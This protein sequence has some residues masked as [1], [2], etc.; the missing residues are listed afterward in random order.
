MYIRKRTVRT[1]ALFG[2]LSERSAFL[3]P[4]RILRILGFAIRTDPG[5]CSPAVRSGDSLGGNTASV[6]HES[7][8]DA[9]SIECKGTDPG[10]HAA[11][12]QG[13]KAEPEG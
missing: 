8:D 4:D 12:N 1:A 5:G 3:A 6:F 13:P 7:D 2:N 10:K 9:E 11:F